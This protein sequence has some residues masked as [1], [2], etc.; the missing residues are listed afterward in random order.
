MWP[1]WVS[2]PGPLTYESGALPTALCG[3]AQ[4]F[5]KSSRMQKIKREHELF[6]SRKSVRNFCSAKAPHIFSVKNGGF[7]CLKY[8]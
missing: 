2:N 4:W 7:F 3:P 5:V 1:N 8:I 6:L